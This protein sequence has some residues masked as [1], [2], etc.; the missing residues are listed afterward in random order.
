MDGSSWL[1][2]SVT[3]LAVE[4]PVCTS[5]QALAMLSYEQAGNGSAKPVLLA[6]DC[7]RRCQADVRDPTLLE[8]LA[9]TDLAP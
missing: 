2:E 5:G 9:I 8:R 3:A 1:D 4:C 6:L 7:V